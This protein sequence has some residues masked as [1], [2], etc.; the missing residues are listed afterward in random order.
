MVYIGLHTL[1]I[2]MLVETEVVGI[3]CK[4]CCGN[5]DEGSVCFRG[6]HVAE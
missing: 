1:R 3:K 6:V 4:S 5:R 2:V